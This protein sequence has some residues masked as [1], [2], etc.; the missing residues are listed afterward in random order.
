VKTI[1]DEQAIL[2][3]DLKEFSISKIE[4]GPKDV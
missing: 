3:Y 2:T 4:A 1:P